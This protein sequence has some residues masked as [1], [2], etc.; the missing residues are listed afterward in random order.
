MHLSE[1]EEAIEAGWWS[2]DPRD[3]L[4]GEGE[5]EYLMDL[6]MGGS[7]AGE[8]KHE[9]AGTSAAPNVQS[10]QTSGKGSTEEGSQ[11][12]REIQGDKSSMSAGPKKGPSKARGA[13]DKESPKRNS[14]AGD[15]GTETGDERARDHRG[16]LESEASAGS[17]AREANAED[18]R[19]PWEQYP[20]WPGGQEGG[21]GQLPPSGSRN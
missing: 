8:D 3:L 19:G 21:G 4:P 1:E 15:T 17:G 9:P 11:A 5:T 20:W 13:H 6:I 2:P 12:Q 14:P 7:G 16:S 18:R 10:R